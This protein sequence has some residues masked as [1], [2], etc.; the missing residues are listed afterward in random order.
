VVTLRAKTAPPSL[1][2]G[3]SEV[4][5]QIRQDQQARGF[6]GLTAQELADEE[7]TRR[8]DDEDVEARWGTL[9]SQ[10]RTGPPR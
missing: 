6:V 8:E 1:R 7:A 10:T 4:I 9:W 5:E 2:P 3:L